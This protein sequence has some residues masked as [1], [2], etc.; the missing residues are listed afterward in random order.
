M[1]PIEIQCGCG[2]KY[3]FEVEPVGGRMPSAVACPACGADGTAAANAI[4][5]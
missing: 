3:A 1:I 4:I 2:Q 5:A